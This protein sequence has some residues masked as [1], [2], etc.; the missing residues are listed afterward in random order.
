M[1]KGKEDS[2]VVEFF[3]SSAGQAWLHK[4]YLATFLIFHQN[5]SS[6]MPALH[7]YFEL[8]GINKFVG[9]SIS[10]LQKV[11]LALDQEIV[12]FGKGESERLGKEMVHKEISGALDENFIMDQMTLILMDPVS[13]YI[14][15]EEVEE[16]RDAETWYTVT[17]AAIKG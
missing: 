13:G 11:S 16:K 6:G 1:L 5:G 3:E 14:L 9:T 4:M 12:I 2:E 17:Q 10:A 7:D 15:A 8:I